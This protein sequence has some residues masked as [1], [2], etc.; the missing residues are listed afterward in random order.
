MHTLHIPNRKYQCDKVCTK[1]NCSLLH[2]QVISIEYDVL[3]GGTISIGI[4]GFNA[5][6][7]TGILSGQHQRNTSPSPRTATEDNYRPHKPLPWRQKIWND[8]IEDLVITERMRPN[9]GTLTVQRGFRDW[10]KQTGRSC[11]AKEFSLR[12]NPGKCLQMSKMEALGVQ[13][14]V[15][16]IS[17]CS[18]GPQGTSW[19]IQASVSRYLSLYRIV[20]S[21]G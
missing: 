12:E 2:T 10:T 9:N 20:G 1:R 5:T 15:I 19:R 4:M 13:P 6:T 17:L 3:R 8:I 7:T 14:Y 18:E 11:K 16:C 21:N